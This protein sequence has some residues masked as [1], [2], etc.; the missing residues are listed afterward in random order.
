[1]GM[2][3]V[4]CRRRSRSGIGSSPKPDRTYAGARRGGLKASLRSP[5]PLSLC[6]A[7]NRLDW[8]AD[9]RRGHR[10]SSGIPHSLSRR[11]IR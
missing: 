9:P 8:A 3:C 2:N 4:R 5:D 10:G 1:M 11:L 7:T 6:R